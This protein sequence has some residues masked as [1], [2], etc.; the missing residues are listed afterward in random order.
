MSF[1]V[2]P[3]PSGEAQWKMI[4]WTGRS[5]FNDYYWRPGEHLKSPRKSHGL[6]TWVTKKIAEDDRE[7]WAGV[8]TRRANGDIAG[9][10]RPGLLL[11]VYI[12]RSDLLKTNG[13]EAE[14]SRLVVTSRDWA[15]AMTTSR[16]P[17]DDRYDKFCNRTRSVTT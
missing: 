15:T 7:F 3:P 1:F 5:W 11:Q 12:Q 13:I 16:T 8:V 17:L 14:Y 9:L 4:K 2:Y 6:F 10:D